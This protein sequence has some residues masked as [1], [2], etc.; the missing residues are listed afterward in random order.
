MKQLIIICFVLLII[1]SFILI[2]SV[3]YYI[4]FDWSNTMTKI[5]QSAIILAI[6]STIAGC[7]LSEQEDDNHEIY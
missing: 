6:I 1:S 7:A 2:L 5:V 4:W 3:F